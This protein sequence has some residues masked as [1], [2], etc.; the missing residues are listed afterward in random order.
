MKK[1]FHSQII[2]NKKAEYENT[3]LFFYNQPILVEQQH[4]QRFQKS[5]L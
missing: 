3:R 4:P 5:Q 1:P 2:Q